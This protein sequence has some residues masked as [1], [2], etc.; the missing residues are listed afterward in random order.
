VKPNLDSSPT[1]L[2]TWLAVPVALLMCGMIVWKYASSAALKPARISM[3]TVNVS[4]VGWRRTVDGWE[5]AE[6]WAITSKA[7]RNIN[8]WIAFQRK[9][10]ASLGQAILER[11]RLIHPLVISTSMLLV[12]VAIA[13]FHERGLR[14]A[15]RNAR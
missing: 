6:Q 1:N 9:Q 2:L 3:T 5:L 12:V 7:E 14:S 8:Q 15:S 13:M 10:E 4:P 11:V